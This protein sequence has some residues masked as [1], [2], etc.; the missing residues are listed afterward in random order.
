[1]DP[2]I[3]DR[4]PLYTRES[5]E[6]LQRGGV[7]SVRLPPRSQVR[8]LGLLGVL[9]Q[10]D[11]PSDAVACGARSKEYDQPVSWAWSDPGELWQEHRAVTRADIESRVV[12]IVAEQL[13]V[14]KDLVTSDASFED[15][16]GADEF[17]QG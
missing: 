6:L 15:D 4:D 8:L 12:K 13:G 17:R 16:L 9:S 5:R 3:H 14:D 1:M 2:N 11:R 10:P 7:T